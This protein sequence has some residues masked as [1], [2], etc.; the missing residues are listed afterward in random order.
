MSEVLRFDLA[1][2]VASGLELGNA[3]CVDVEADDRRALSRKGGGDRQSHIAKSNDGELSTVRHYFP[4][5]RARREGICPR[6]RRTAMIAV[7]GADTACP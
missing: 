4:P 2:T 7:G 6:I 5:G 1:G 3:P